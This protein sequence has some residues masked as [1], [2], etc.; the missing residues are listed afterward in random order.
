M[1][2]NRLINTLRR[3]CDL[4]PKTP[5]VPRVYSVGFSAVYDKTSIR[6]SLFRAGVCSDCFCRSNHFIH[7][8]Y[9]IKL[10]AQQHLTKYKRIFTCTLLRLSMHQCIQSTAGLQ[11]SSVVPAGKT[12]TGI[13]WIGEIFVRPAAKCPVS[14]K[15]YGFYEGLS[16]RRIQP[17]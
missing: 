6:P 13:L 7:N 15:D 12:Y 5:S 8:T 11:T 4:A 14:I 17:L 9:R 16:R 10:S 1:P 2:V 3:R